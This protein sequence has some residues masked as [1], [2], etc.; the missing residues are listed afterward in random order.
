MQ[1]LFHHG[2]EY[3]NAFMP[4][5]HHPTLHIFSS[6]PVLALAICSLGGLTGTAP[7]W[8]EVGRLLQDHIMCRSFTMSIRFSIYCELFDRNRQL[9]KSTQ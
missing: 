6:S 4:F 8:Y 9:K 3:L 7:E 1:A 5:L 2:L